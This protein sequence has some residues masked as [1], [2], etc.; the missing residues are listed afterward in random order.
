MWTTLR[1]YSHDIF[2][3]FLMEMIWPTIL[4][5]LWNNKVLCHEVLLPIVNCCNSH[6]D[7][8]VK[9]IQHLAAH[10][11]SL[12][13]SFLS[14]L[15]LFIYLLWSYRGW[16][17]TGWKV[18]ENVTWGI[19]KIICDKFGVI[20]AKEFWTE[21]K[22]KESSVGDTSGKRIEPSSYLKTEEIEPEYWECLK[23]NH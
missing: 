16:P 5:N 7:S 1:R 6:H 20:Q 4:S 23:K 21:E 9:F 15:A 8:L 2:V 10:G 12:C 11:E 19:I 14:K 18:Y 13:L 3:L 22:I 17:D